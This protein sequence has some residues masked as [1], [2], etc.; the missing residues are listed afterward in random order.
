[1]L[2]LGR[3]DRLTT[4][5]P[6]DEA[7]IDRELVTLGVAAE[8]IVI[9]EHEDA[10][11]RPGAAIEIGGRKS[12]DAAADHHEIIAFLWLG[13]AGRILG[14]RTHDCVRSFEAADMLSPQACE[15]RRVAGGLRRNLHRGREP[16]RNRQRKAVEEIAA[17]DITHAPSP[18]AHAGL[19][20][21]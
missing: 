14:W 18:C 20:S 19:A 5:V 21:I 10:R 12:A 6:D 13:P 9:V 1:P 3:I 2:R 4:A 16:G 11:L 17:G 15:R 8:I 7:A